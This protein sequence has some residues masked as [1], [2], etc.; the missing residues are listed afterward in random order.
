M[1]R[2][3]REYSSGKYVWSGLTFKVRQCFFGSLSATV[4]IV[5][6]LPALHT[7]AHTVVPTCTSLSYYLTKASG[8]AKGAGRTGR[9][10][11]GGDR[12]EKLFLKIDVEIQIH[13][14]YHFTLFHKRHTTMNK[15]TI[16][17]LASFI[18]FHCINYFISRKTYVNSNR[19]TTAGINRQYLHFYLSQIKLHKWVICQKHDV[20]AVHLFTFIAFCFSA[21]SSYVFVSKLLRDIFQYFVTAIFF[22]ENKSLLRSQRQLPNTKYFQSF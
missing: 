21:V 19:R 9:H 3:W 11:L 13:H 22:V 8:V 1:Y 16:V 14:H 17:K 5:T 6:I 18:L 2:T 10:L 15:R 12:R 7:K 20:M 4:S